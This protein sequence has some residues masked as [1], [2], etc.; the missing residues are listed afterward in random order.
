QLMHFLLPSYV[1]E[2]KSYLT[3]AIGCTGGMHRSVVIAEQLGR[4]IDRDS[5]YNVK[6]DHRDITKKI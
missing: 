2:G 4:E 3:V 6:V 1:R 5:L